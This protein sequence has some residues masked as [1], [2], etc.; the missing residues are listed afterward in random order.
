MHLV[1][2]CVDVLL[3][4]H[5]DYD[6]EYTTNEHEAHNYKRLI[7]DVLGCCFIP[8][9]HMLSISVRTIQKPKPSVS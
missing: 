9:D 7:L 3:L 6:E 4:C 8:S 5:S 1:L 2:I